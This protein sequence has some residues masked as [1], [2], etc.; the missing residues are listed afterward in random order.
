LLDI[1]SK[2]LNDRKFSMEVRP[3]IREM[4]LRTSTKLREKKRTLVV[5]NKRKRRLGSKNGS[6][7]TSIRA[8]PVRYLKK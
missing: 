4:K 7:S 6:T 3:K 8:T 5:V 2:D 1:K